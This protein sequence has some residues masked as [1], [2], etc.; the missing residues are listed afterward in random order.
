MSF[1]LMAYEC[2]KSNQYAFDEN[3]S[4]IMMTDTCI[5]NELDENLG[6]KC[7]ENCTRIKCPDGSSRFSSI[8]NVN[9]KN[10][11]VWFCS[12]R[13]KKDSM[14]E[15]CIPGCKH[16]HGGEIKHHKD[17]PFYPESLSRIYDNMIEENRKLKFMV[18]NGLGWE[19]LKN[20]ISYP[21]DID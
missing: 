5:A 10:Y 13:Q 3:A 11:N 6:F 21:N 20:D 2:I 7:T 9:G 17:C 1:D 15:K 18:D 14:K 8:I 16:F 4:K 19:D 12:P